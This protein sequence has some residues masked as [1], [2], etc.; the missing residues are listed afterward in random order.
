M[1]IKKTKQ[2]G[3]FTVC[4][5]KAV[6]GEL[7]ISGAKTTLCLRDPEF[8]P[9]HD[10]PDQNI[11]G[12]LH[13]LTKVTLIHCVTPKVPGHV[14][15]P[16]GTYYFAK[17]FAHFV[18]TGE[19]FIKPKDQAISGAVIYLD[20]AKRLF[21][22]ME[23][24][25]EVFID[26][27]PIVE[28]IMRR[29]TNRTI[30][31]SG[32]NAHILYYTG[33][34]EIVVS[35]TPFGRISIEH[36]PNVRSTGNKG[37]IL[38]D[39][40]AVSLDFDTMLTFSDAIDRVGKIAEYLGLLVG[41]PQ[42]LTA[43]YMEIQKEESTG[44]LLKVDWTMYGGRRSEA[45]AEKP[46]SYDVLIDATRQPSEF[47]SVLRAWLERQKEWGSARWRFFNS[48]ADQKSYSIDRLVASANMFDILPPTAVPSDNPLSPELEQARASSRDLFKKLQVTP[49]RA[50]VLGCL[51]RLG[52][53]SLKRKIRH[54][55]M[56]LIDHASEAFPELILVTDE[57]VN[58]RNYYVH[59]S[60]GSF[61]YNK[62]F[63]TV[64]FFTD[65]LEFVFA[66][67]DLIEA[68]WNF[69]HWLKQGTSMSHPFGRYKVVYQNSL[70]Q[71]LSLLPSRT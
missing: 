34:D 4:Q 56:F 60:D 61:D 62:N 54:R 37:R 53:S 15:G 39:E 45:E 68:G 11:T 52:K 3:T 41:R 67:S 64:V 36:R 19:H 31:K 25:G 44:Q 6:Y 16:K 21:D 70:Q 27:Q 7:T 10:L 38:Q 13:D 32:P 5:D 23:A 43:L 33:K 57:A 55:V 18:V 49:E 59:G 58:C 30:K 47:A 48:F 1:M 63:D 66:A 17:V 65:T 69:K 51:G 50:S 42:N 2:A 26:A 46:S 71:L 40:V 35:E 9:T 14:S 29:E 20:D 8:F 22:D 24:F 28:E 12:I